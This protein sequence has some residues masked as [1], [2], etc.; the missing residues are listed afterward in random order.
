MNIDKKIKRIM[1]IRGNAP[2]GSTIQK[3]ANKELEFLYNKKYK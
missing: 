2:A 1:E 3:M